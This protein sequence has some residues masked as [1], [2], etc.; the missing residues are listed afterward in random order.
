MRFYSRAIVLQ[1]DM[2]NV[3]EKENA[4]DNE[5]ERLSEMNDTFDIKMQN[6]R[7]ELLAEALEGEKFTIKKG[8]KL[9]FSLLFMYGLF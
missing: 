8:A 5:V 4:E 2:I 9:L 1:G 6:L 7:K 3:L